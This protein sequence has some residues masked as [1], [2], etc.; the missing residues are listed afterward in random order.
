L[1]GSLSNTGLATHSKF[2]YDEVF[3]RAEVPVD[4]E[5]LRTFDTEKPDLVVYVEC[6]GAPCVPTTAAFQAMNGTPIAAIWW[7][8]TKGARRDIPGTVVNILP[9]GNQAS[10]TFRNPLP[11]WSPEDS[12]LYNMDIEKKD[13]A[14][15]YVGSRGHKVIGRED[16]EFLRRNRVPLLTVGG[17]REDKL[18]ADLYANYIKR[19]R[20]SLNWTRDMPWLQH[21]LKGRVF[22]ITMC[23]AMLL[24]TEGDQTPHYLTP[25]TE[26]V[27]F[28]SQNDLLDKVTYYLSHEEERAAIAL[29]GHHR[30]TTCWNETNWW[31]Q[32]FDAVKAQ[33]HGFPWGP[34]RGQ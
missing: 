4:I 32:V 25:G 28:S 6:I 29:A 13:L 18:P 22:E 16:V 19:S 17:Q 34:R 11:L 8:S 7:D 14:I 30:T 24:E 23:G 3:L 5:L 15:T 33:H 12:T 20:I 26:Y 9:D 1:F 27:P 21:Q 2:H 10:T 31:T